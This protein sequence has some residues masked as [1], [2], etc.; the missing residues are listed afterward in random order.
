MN[1]DEGSYLWHHLDQNQLRARW[2][3]YHHCY[4]ISVNNKSPSNKIVYYCEF[5]T[6]LEPIDLRPTIIKIDFTAHLNY[7]R[8]YS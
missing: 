2:K 7:N 4:I 3:S 1:E 5:I 8:N 6:L